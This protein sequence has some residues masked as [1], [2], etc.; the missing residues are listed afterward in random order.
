MLKG[1]KT[2]NYSMRIYLETVENIVGPHGLRSILNYAH[3]E[4]YIDNFPPD[5]DRMDIPLKDLQ[6]LCRSLLEMFGQ[7]GVRSLQLRIGRQIIRR[8]LEKLPR[9]A[10]IMRPLATSL[11]PEYVKMRFSLERLIKAVKKRYP[12]TEDTLLPRLELQE[13]KDCF[14]VVYRDNWESEE[15]ISQSPVCSVTVGSIEAFLEWT[16]GHVHEVVEIECRAIGHPADVFRISKSYKKEEPVGKRS[17]DSLFFRK[18][19]I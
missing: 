4:K 18:N 1:R 17:L 19:A 13:E 5:N 14:L 8:S 10:K 9:I 12:P 3:L 2:D 11:I 15:V 16:T 6:N 7:K